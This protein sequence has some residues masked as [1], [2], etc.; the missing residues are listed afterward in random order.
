MK[1]LGSAARACYPSGTGRQSP[2]EPEGTDMNISRG[3]L[4]MG[5]VYLLV[6]ILIGAY[7]GGSGDSTLVPVHAHI[8]LL[9]FTL[10]TLFGLGYRLIPG[11]AE[12]TLP[13]V[14]FWLHQVGA[15]LLLLGLYL[16]LT[17]KVAEATIGPAFPVLEGAILL[18]VILWLVALLRRT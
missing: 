1:S 12:G 7:M 3:F 16:M 18:G 9:G 15:F 6:G 14:H 2:R 4:V 13:K 11:L 8:N 5:A 17:G 10:M